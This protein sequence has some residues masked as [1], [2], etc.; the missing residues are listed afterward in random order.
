[1]NRQAHV[2]CDVNY[3]FINEGLLKVTRTRMHCKCDSIS[4]TVPDGVVSTNDY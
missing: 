3:F 1:M 2:A 4:E